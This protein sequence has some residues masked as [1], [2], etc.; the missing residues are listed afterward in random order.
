MRYL[1]AM[2]L[3]SI[4]GLSTPAFAQICCPSGCSADSNPPRCVFNGTT[5]TCGQVP[6][7]P[8]PQRTPRPTGPGT[9]GDSPPGAGFAPCLGL[10][11]IGAEL[12][13]KC[14]SELSGNA[15]L[16]HC[17]F[18]GENSA[19]R[20]ED[21]RTDLSCPAR[22]AK[23][24]SQCQARCSRFAANFQVCSDPN[25]QWQRFFG[26][27][28]GVAFGSAHVELC[29]PPLASGSRPFPSYRDRGWNNR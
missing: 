9:P 4:C 8:T 2:M 16:F 11:V 3:V 14:I 27:I 7:A 29:G 22:Q 1:R 5:S 21:S 12:V 20:A 18:F 25:S 13:K 10:G 24:A 28:G 26:D 17:F 6:C 19:D 15:Q 23:L